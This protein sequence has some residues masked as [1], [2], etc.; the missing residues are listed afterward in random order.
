MSATLIPLTDLDMDGMEERELGERS[1]VA[2][3][4]GEAIAMGGCAVEW[5]SS[6]LQ[7]AKKYLAEN[8]QLNVTLTQLGRKTARTQKVRGGKEVEVE[9]YKRELIAIRV[10]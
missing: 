10:A 8:A 1:D 6:Q 5:N 4:I 9:R 2:K 3:T 7:S